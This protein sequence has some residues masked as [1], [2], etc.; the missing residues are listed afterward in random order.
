MVE[1]AGAAAAAAALIPQKP[2]VW[3]GGPQLALGSLSASAV[4]DAGPAKY[5]W[6][7]QSDGSAGGT[8]I[9]TRFRPWG[10]SAQPEGWARLTLVKNPLG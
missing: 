3:G 6:L 4:R 8:A 9:S 10:K 7:E 2:S 1:L 5:T